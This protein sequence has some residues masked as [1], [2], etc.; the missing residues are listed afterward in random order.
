MKYMVMECHKGYAVLMD[1]DSRFVN[2]AN[3]HYTVG[4][5]VT[6]PVLMQN[7]ENAKSKRRIVMTVASAA[8]CLAIAAGAGYYHYVQNYKVYSTVLISS[9][10]EIK[11]YLNKKGKVLY[12]KSDS[13]KGNEIIK[14]YE[15]KGKDK[16]TAAHELIEIG[17]SKGYI[18]ENEPVDIFISSEGYSNNR[19]DFEN[20]FSDYKLNV[21]DM[22]E[23]SSKVSETFAST[24]IPTPF[25][26]EPAKA[27]EVHEHTPDT[28]PQIQPPKAEVHED[29]A[30][31]VTKMTPEQPPV[32]HEEAVSPKAN[33]KTEHP[34]NGISIPHEAEKPEIPPHEKKNQ[35]EETV[36]DTPKEKDADLPVRPDDTIKPERHVPNKEKTVEPEIPL[37]VHHPP[38]EELFESPVHPDAEAPA[39]EIHELPSPDEELTVIDDNTDIL[40]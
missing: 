16:L 17:V 23:F 15:A 28:A 33:I 34:N 37:P 3:L 11:M 26:T 14:D 7:T 18:S 36:D 12:L 20:D 8:A 24:T 29:K 4:Q 5:T 25:V 10:A 31:I 40:Q 6:D 13:T 32:Q 2:A 30:P 38:H 35:H 21:R 19:S 22:N 39:P 27:P 9:D 1:E